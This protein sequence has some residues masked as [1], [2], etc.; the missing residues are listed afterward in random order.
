MLASLLFLTFLTRAQAQTTQQGYND[1]VK[2]NPTADQD[3]KVVSDYLNALVAA[4]FDKAKGLVAVNY[5]GYGP[6]P[7]DSA[8]I[9]QAIKFWQAND[10]TETNR[11]IEFTPATFKV[12]SGTY[13]GNWVAMWGD[14]SCTQA[15]KDLRFPFQY[16]AHITNGKI[17]QDIVY[18]DRLYIYQALGFTVTPP[19]QN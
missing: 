7:Q 6:G 16:T 14:Y 1:A 3:I 19:K 12:L 2:T 11:K 10:S 4:D 8:T 13:E 9:E 17:D 18:Y 15:G 5:K